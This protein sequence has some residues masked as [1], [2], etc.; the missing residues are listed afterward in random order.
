MTISPGATHCSPL[1]LLQ[2]SLV[3]PSLCL[4]PAAPALLPCLPR[5]IFNATD[6]P[7]LLILFLPLG[8][9]RTSPTICHPWPA[10]AVT[11]HPT[12]TN[13]INVKKLES[14]E[15]RSP[16]CWKGCDSGF[17]GERRPA[18]S[19]VTGDLR[20]HPLDPAAPKE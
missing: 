9:S 12:P 19:A 2:A 7:H 20:Y 3:P 13:R 15:S 6:Q 4:S 16:R 18:C 11:V 1:Q 10:H 5:L 14:T 8:Q 17:K